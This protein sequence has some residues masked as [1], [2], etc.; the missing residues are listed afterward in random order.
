MNLNAYDTVD[1][2]AVSNSWINLR[3]R[4]L[5][6]KTIKYYPVFT[7]LK[8]YNVATK[9]YDYYL[10]MAN[11]QMTD[12]NTWHSAERY[13]NS[14]KLSLADIWDVVKKKVTKPISY[15]DVTL[16]TEDEDCSVYSID[17]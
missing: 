8:R 13:K 9:K 1:D 15:V 6:S 4:K 3:Y 17:F 5:Y 14:V 16:Q 7:F 12:S 10:A 2:G 11:K